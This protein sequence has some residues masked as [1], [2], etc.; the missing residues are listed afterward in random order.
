[1]DSYANDSGGL[2][3]IRDT[4]AHVFP[5]G[6]IPWS[7]PDDGGFFAVRGLSRGM[8]PRNCESLASG[9][10]KARIGEA[11]RTSYLVRTPDFLLFFR[12]CPDTMGLPAGGSVVSCGFAPLLSSLAADLEAYALR[13]IAARH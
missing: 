13:S 4:L 9:C 5:S 8:A 2:M 1:M 3:N 11:P 6:R 10:A 7:V 12:T